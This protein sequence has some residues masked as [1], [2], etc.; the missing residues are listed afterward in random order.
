MNSSI[1]ESKSA[2]F[3][4]AEVQHAEPIHHLEGPNGINIVTSATRWDF[5]ADQWANPIYLP[6]GE[7]EAFLDAWKAYRERVDNPMV[8]MG[9][10][11][12]GEGEEKIKVSSEEALIDQFVRAVLYYIPGTMPAEKL[13]QSIQLLA[14]QE[15]FQASHLHRAVSSHIRQHPH[16]AREGWMKEIDR[17]LAQIPPPDV[18]S[19]TR[20]VLNLIPEHA[21]PAYL[22]RAIE[23]AS[24]REG[25]DF[26]SIRRA[27][28]S[29]FLNHPYQDQEGWMNKIEDVLKGTPAAL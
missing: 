12:Q 23:I 14:S 28:D 10:K 24:T 21:P 26:L 8:V 4:L 2:I 6:E 7:R 13:R 1:Y 18:W 5:T 20:D 9:E 3:P 27:I 29:N 16:Q 25:F 15:G 11:R 22:R 17:V 19:I